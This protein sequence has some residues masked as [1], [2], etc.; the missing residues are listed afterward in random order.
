[1]GYVFFYFAVV[2][3]CLLWSAA[4]T[5]VAARTR[6]GW[7]RRLLAAVAV[8]V[9]PLAVAPWAW[10]TG[11]LAALGFETNWFAPTLT[12]MIAAAIGGVWIA[13][14]GLAPRAA[15]AAAT[16]PLVGL[17]A[18]FVVAKA[19]AAGTLLFIDNA[20]R[21][22]ARAARAEAVAVMQSIVPPPVPADD[23]AVP[24]YRQVFERLAA[25]DQLA[26]EESPLADV[27]AADL[28]APSVTDLLARQAA[29]LELL[30]RAADRPGYR[31][32]RDWSRPRIDML[33]PEIQ[34]MRQAAR[35]LALAARR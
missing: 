24:L 15:P 14:A 21:A 19:V 22:E 1:M 17:A 29:T 32:P 27:A 33:L 12:A 8:I 13:V 35:L 23:D 30:R 18:M 2:A 9:P 6:P 31:F 10:V 25:D 20:V 11:W 26:G 4:F 3:A 7:I 28:S 34:S 16:W 5:A